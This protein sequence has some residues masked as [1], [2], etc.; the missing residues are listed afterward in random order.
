MHL[1]ISLKCFIILYSY[2]KN[3]E[4]VYAHKH[5]YANDESYIL[6]GYMR[7]RKLQLRSC[8]FI[9]R[10]IRFQ[11]SWQLLHLVKRTPSFV[12]LVT[13]PL[14]ASV[15]SANPVV[16]CVGKNVHKH[17][18]KFRKLRLVVPDCKFHPGQRWEI[19]LM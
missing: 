18:L 7:F 6:H 15:T 19:Q 3:G 13:K 2:I 9:R 11:V 17:D 10:R 4:R 14:Y 1:E 12:A 8:S 16:D 5:N